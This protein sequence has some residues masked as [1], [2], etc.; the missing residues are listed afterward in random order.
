MSTYAHAGIQ[1][2]AFEHVV[3]S[4][5]TAASWCRMPYARPGEGAVTAKCVLGL[6]VAGEEALGEFLP[7]G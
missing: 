6:G 4:V 7:G 5:L 2:D 1:P 3:E